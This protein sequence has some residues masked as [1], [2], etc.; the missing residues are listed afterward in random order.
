MTRFAITKTLLGALIANTAWGTPQPEPA[1]IAKGLGLANSSGH[2]PKTSVLDENARN[3]V[4]ATDP[5]DRQPSPFNTSCPYA[6]PTEAEAVARGGNPSV[7]GN[8]VQVV[9]LAN[10]RMGNRFMGLSNA[11]RLGYCCKSKMV[12][13]L[14]K[15]KRVAPGIFAEGSRGPRWF[16]FSGAPDVVGFNFSSCP[17]NMTLDGGDTYRLNRVDLKP[18]ADGKPHPDDTPGLKECIKHAPRL[19]GCEGA[20]FFPADVNVC[21]SNRPDYDGVQTPITDHP[22]LEVN[23][24]G[25]LRAENE[26]VTA[27]DGNLV[28]HVRSGDIFSDD[29]LY[30]YVSEHYGQPPLQYYVRIIEEYDWSRVDV[31]TNGDGDLNPVI[32]ALESK[33]AQG[34]LSGEIFFHKD[35]AL[36]EDLV[37]ML[38]A[39]GLAT[40]RSTISSLT[41]FHSTATRIFFP[42]S[43]SK[44]QYVKD[45]QHQ[46]PAIKTYGALFDEDSYDPYHFWNNSV[47]QRTA[48]VDFEVI[49]LEECVSDSRG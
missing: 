26:R 10:G 21:N 8:I 42:R 19:I 6:I 39:D 40:A 34:E 16:D 18:H 4:N 33:V 14:A 13:L 20:Y 48:M 49:G 44:A 2:R 38:C 45:L 32:P 22:S 24:T 3:V 5:D 25:Q 46:R 30:P 31:V 28:I 17:T 9:S 11:L 35:R 37:S 27:K 1:A 43:C 15:N 23:G 29:H 36:D 12:A 47:E 7:P 41:L